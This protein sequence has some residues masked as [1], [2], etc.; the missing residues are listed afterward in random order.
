MACSWHNYC[1]RLYI[2][3]HQP[4]STSHSITDVTFRHDFQYYLDTTVL[5]DEMLCITGDFNL[6][7]D[8]PNDPYGCQFSNLPSRY[9]LVNHVTFPMHQA[10]HTLD[11]VIT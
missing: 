9:G 11:L 7:I 2:V 4:Y 1:I 3:Y 5:V 10:G 6:H 8:D